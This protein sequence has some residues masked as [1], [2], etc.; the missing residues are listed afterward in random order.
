MRPGK[1]NVVCDGQ[2]GS[3]GKGLISSYLAKKY[4]IQSASTTCMANSGHTAVL[5]DGTKFIAK[6]LPAN[7]ILNLQNPGRMTF[8]IGATAGFYLEQLFKEIAECKLEQNQV[9]IHSRAMVITED[10]AA[11][12]RSGVK[13]IASTMQGSA[14]A[15]TKKIMRQQGYKLARDYPELE[16]YIVDNMH[17][18]VDTMLLPGFAHMWLH[19]CSQGFSLSI[20]HGSHYP[21]CTSRDCTATAALSDMGVAP[22]KIGDVYLVIRPYPIRVGNVVENGVEVGNSGG[23]YRDQHEMTWDEVKKNCGAPD[24]LDLKEL[25]TV[26]KRIRRVASFSPEQLR[27]AVTVNGATKIALNFA[28]YLDWSLFENRHNAADM[29]VSDFSSKVRNFITDIEQLVNVPVSLVGIGPQINNVVD[30]E[31]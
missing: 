26:T 14:A 9:K 8:Y 21:A 6:I 2:H 12:E 28:N 4:N 24:D 25:T 1:F 3:T 27:Q 19:D 11:Q 17:E 18:L 15:L 23:W 30:L 13:Y 10:D 20:N 29:K 22:Q 16:P 7:A 5:E 31:I